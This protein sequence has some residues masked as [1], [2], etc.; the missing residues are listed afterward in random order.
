MKQN[1]RRIALDLEAA[2]PP[3]FLRGV[4][5]GVAKDALLLGLHD[6]L[7]GQVMEDL[8]RTNVDRKLVRLNLPI[9][10]FDARL[11][12]VPDRLSDLPLRVLAAEPE[13]R[14]RVHEQ[15]LPLPKLDNRDARFD[16]LEL[17]VPDWLEVS[18]VDRRGAPL[19]EG[20]NDRTI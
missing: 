2:L 14:R 8:R 15:R 20:V 9:V 4:D 13:L 16:G 19:V 7:P 11:V 12:L 10:H 17:R 5:T 6:N 3:V 18:G 1:L